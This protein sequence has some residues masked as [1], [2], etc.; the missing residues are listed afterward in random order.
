[1]ETLSDLFFRETSGARKQLFNDIP[2]QYFPSRPEIFALGDPNG[3]KL[4]DTREEAMSNDLRVV[5]LT[6]Q[7]Q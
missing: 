4:V 7:K 5:F 6:L 1:M 2:S 3:L